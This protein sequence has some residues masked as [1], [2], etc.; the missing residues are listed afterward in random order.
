MRSLSGIIRRAK[1]STSNGLRAWS[2]P[3]AS[4]ASPPAWRQHTG[5]GPRAP[6]RLD[7][8]AQG[9]RG[10]LLWKPPARCAHP[11]IAPAGTVRGLS[12]PCRTQRPI[13]PPTGR[14][15]QPAHPTH[16]QPDSGIVQ[17]LECVRDSTRIR[18]EPR[19]DI[20]IVHGVL[21]L[22][23]G[24]QPSFANRGISAGFSIWACSMEPWACVLAAALGTECVRLIADGM[25]TRWRTHGMS[26]R[27]NT[28]R[29]GRV[30]N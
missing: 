17:C 22:D 4:P 18:P 15:A 14:A 28:S 21:W 25:G 24:G 11:S 12:F 5:R 6:G 9:G 30:R 26:P 8:R 10:R 29:S 23:A 1:R 3:P 27:G 7:L 20:A 19:D 2:P 13:S 16:A